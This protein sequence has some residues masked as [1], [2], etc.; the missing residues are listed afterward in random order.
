M[1]KVKEIPLNAIKRPLPRQNDPQK[2][3]A[4]MESIAE[5]GQQEPIDVLEVDGQYYGFSGCH[6][7]EACQRLGKET[8][9]A[10]VRKAPKS[11]LKMH[12][13]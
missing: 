1:N 13:A 11:V 3:Q 9:L 8:I 7:Y 4:L 12:I 2:V 10:R 5:I 6:R